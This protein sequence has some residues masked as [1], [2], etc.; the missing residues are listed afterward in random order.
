MQC[1]A[2]NL[3]HRKSHYMMVRHEVLEAY[4]E[5]LTQDQN[6]A[7]KKYILAYFDNQLFDYKFEVANEVLR[8]VNED[9]YINTI[10]L[11]LLEFLNKVTNT[12]YWKFCCNH[13][14][15]YYAYLTKDPNETL[16][17]HVDNQMKTLISVVKPFIEILLFMIK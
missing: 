17:E 9:D 7:F 6:K 8:Q 2:I 12:N 5:N 1:S 16:D 3:Y 13:V 15:A 11:Q 14:L 4:D 10:P